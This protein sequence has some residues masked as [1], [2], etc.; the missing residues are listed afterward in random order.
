MKKALQLLQRLTVDYPPDARCHHC[1]IT[2]GEF[3]AIQMVLGGKFYGLKLDDDD[4]QQPLDILM[5]RIQVELRKNPT[6]PKKD[7]G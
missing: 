1:L 2:E 3:L 5:E 7:A 6:F 4:I